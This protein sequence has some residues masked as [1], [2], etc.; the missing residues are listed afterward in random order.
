[1]FYASLV[2]MLLAYSTLLVSNYILLQL[3]S[4]DKQM[5]ALVDKL[6]NRFAGVNGNM[7]MPS[8]GQI[9]PHLF[10]STCHIWPACILGCHDLHKVGLVPS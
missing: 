2:S 4:Q 5:E 7:L 1:M 9:V 8:I 3:W 10:A 6:C